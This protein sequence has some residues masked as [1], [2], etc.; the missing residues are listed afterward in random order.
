[1]MVKTT[2]L[3]C[4]GPS[5]VHL[6]SVW[7]SSAPPITFGWSSTV[8]RRPVE[9]ASNWSI[10][11]SYYIGPLHCTHF[12]TRGLDLSKKE[13]L[14][15]PN[16]VSILIKSTFLVRVAHIA[17]EWQEE[18]S[19]WNVIALFWPTECFLQATNSGWWLVYYQHILHMAILPISEPIYVFLDDSQDD[20]HDAITHYFTCYLQTIFHSSALSGHTFSDNGALVEWICS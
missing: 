20:S 9:K 18:G 2:L 16:K 1:M 4:W 11:V 8:M 6:C 5:P 19:R 3:T 17:D 7:P 10:P 12:S 15:R 14:F 13:T